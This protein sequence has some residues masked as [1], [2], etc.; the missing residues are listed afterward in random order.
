M[1]AKSES[2][3]DLNACRADTLV[4]E[5]DDNFLNLEMEKSESNW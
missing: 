2:S 4:V 1:E 3:F 5:A